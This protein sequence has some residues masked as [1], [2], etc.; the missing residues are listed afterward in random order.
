M[1]V[2]WCVMSLSTDNVQHKGVQHQVMTVRTHPEMRESVLRTEIL[3]LIHTSS[4]V[5]ILRTVV[6]GA[7]ND[8]CT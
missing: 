1:Y 7:T 6:K 8:E 5:I 2:K 3:F 4:D